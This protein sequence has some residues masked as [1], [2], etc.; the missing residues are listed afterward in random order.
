[1]PVLVDPQT[2]A[3]ATRGGR[4]A[5]SIDGLPVTGRVVGVL[6]RFPT[7]PTGSAGFVVADGPTLNAALDAQ[8]PGQGRPD[9][10]WIDTR[11]ISDLRSALATGQL[12]QL[13]TSFRADIERRLTRAPIGRAVLGALAGATGLAAG[14][15]IVGL[16]VALVGALRNPR[17][18]A[19]LAGQGAGPRW[20]RAELRL[21]LGLAALIGVGAGVVIALLLTPLALN[22]VQAASTLQAP[23]PPLVTVTPGGALAAWALGALAVLM[24][25]GWAGT[26]AMRMEPRQ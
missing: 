19:D 24:L 20:M 7:V 17:I 22:S 15:A 12:A 4:L 10:L 2:A 6:H 25:A 16:L 3:A 26:R 11:H 9:E 14:L 23:Q 8:L 21:R 13:T 18:E 1:V 5:L